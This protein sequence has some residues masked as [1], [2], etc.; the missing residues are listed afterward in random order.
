MLGAR[1]HDVAQAVEAELLVL[2]RQADDLGL[3][4]LVGLRV[5]GALG[6]PIGEGDQGRDRDGEHG[7]VDQ[8][9]AI[10]LGA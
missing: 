9:D 6:V 8:N 7:D 4:G 10:G 5:E 1:H 2:L 3:D